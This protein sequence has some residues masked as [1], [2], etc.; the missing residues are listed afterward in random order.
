MS[1]I[2]KSGIRDF[3]DVDAV[4]GSTKEFAGFI[5]QLDSAGQ[6]SR[7]PRSRIAAVQGVAADLA[8]DVDSIIKHVILALGDRTATIINPMAFGY[9]PSIKPYMQDLEQARK[10]LA[11]A[12]YPNGFE[13]GFLRTQPVVEPGLV[14]TSDVLVA[15]LAKVGIRTKSRMVGE[16]GPLHPISSATT[17]PID[18][19]IRGVDASSL[20]A[21]CD[22]SSSLRLLT[23]NQPYSYYCNRRST[24]SSSSLVPLGDRSTPS[25]SSRTRGPRRSAQ[26]LIRTRHH[27]P[28]SYVEPSVHLMAT[29]VPGDC[30]AVVVTAQPCIASTRSHRPRNEIDRMFVAN[31][32]TARRHPYRLGPRSTGTQRP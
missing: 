16:V 31:T 17:R 23:C 20:P 26:K 30:W 24:T 14:Q 29:D 27:A 21:V 8:V 4:P 19:L 9:D 25:F 15:D 5:A 28:F 6:R 32:C 22:A 10:L 7:R 3:A 1:V 18:V 12:G 13:V 11:E 2:N